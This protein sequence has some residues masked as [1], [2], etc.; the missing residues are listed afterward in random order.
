ML[1]LPFTFL[2]SIF[3]FAVSVNN[4]IVLSDE[5]GK[6]HLVNHLVLSRDAYCMYSVGID[7]MASFCCP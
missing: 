6:Q 2:F 7:L 1:F 4:K 3:D 5:T